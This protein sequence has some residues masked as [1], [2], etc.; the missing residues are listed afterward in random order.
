MQVAQWITKGSGRTVEPRPSSAEWS[1]VRGASTPATLISI[2][3][4]GTACGRSE[5][6]PGGSLQGPGLP[7]QFPRVL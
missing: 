1:Q 2:L 5:G 6:Q 7:G 3:E 4:V